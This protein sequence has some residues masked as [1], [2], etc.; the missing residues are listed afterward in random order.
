MPQLDWTCYFNLIFWFLLTFVF[1]YFVISRVLCYQIHRTLSIR[2]DK[3]QSFITKRQEYKVKIYT[4]QKKIDFYLVQ[5]L[6]VIQ[7]MSFMLKKQI[8]IEELRLN[9]S[10]NKIIQ[11][12]SKYHQFSLQDRTTRYHRE[13]NTLSVDIDLLIKQHLLK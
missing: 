3:V 13:L 5:Y 12:L 1:L 8:S 2:R 10:Y 9:K 11:V 7:T 6:K 4:S